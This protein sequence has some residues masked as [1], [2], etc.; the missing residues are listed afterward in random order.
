MLFCF[1]YYIET[2]L[3]SPASD[4][5]SAAGTKKHQYCSEDGRFVCILM[6]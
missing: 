5:D 6:R 1:Y 4:S 2:A 3:K